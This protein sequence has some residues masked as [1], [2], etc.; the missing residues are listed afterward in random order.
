[1]PTME[2]FK[3]IFLK[4]GLVGTIVVVVVSV[5]LARE[6]KDKYERIAKKYP[7][8]SDKYTNETPTWTEMMQ[9]VLLHEYLNS[10]SDNKSEYKIVAE[11]SDQIPGLKVTRRATQNEVVS[12]APADKK[13]E[14]PPLV[15]GTI[16]KYTC[17]AEEYSSS[18][19]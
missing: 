15:V 18:L 2:L 3:S 4:G 16:R 8:D 14:K 7:I 9:T 5:I 1:M 17:D 12:D 13:T 6:K 19:D 10:T 11:A